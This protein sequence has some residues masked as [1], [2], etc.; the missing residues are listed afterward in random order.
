MTAAGQNNLNFSRFSSEGRDIIVP[1][2]E[3]ATDVPREPQLPPDPP[4]GYASAYDRNLKLYRTLTGMGLN[5]Q[6][7]PAEDDPTKIGCLIVSVGVLPLSVRGP[8]KGSEVAEGVTPTVTDR[9][10][11]VDFP[12]IF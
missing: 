3:N 7:K 6:A 8:L 1:R 9:S 10:N 11:V 4:D 2:L 5:V 12:T